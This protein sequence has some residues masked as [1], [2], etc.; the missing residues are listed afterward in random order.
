MDVQSSWMKMD[1]MGCQR[2]AHHQDRAVP[3]SRVHNN[4]REEQL[5]PRVHTRIS[6]LFC[7]HLSIRGVQK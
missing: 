2:A 5:F 4:P 6:P 3:V 1:K 7:P